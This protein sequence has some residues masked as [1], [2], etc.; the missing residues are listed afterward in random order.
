MGETMSPAEKCI[1]RPPGP[2]IT[3]VEDPIEARAFAVL[4]DVREALIALTAF[5]RR[6][7]QV[8]QLRGFHVLGAT[9]NFSGKDY[10]ELFA[11]GQGPGGEHSYVCTPIVQASIWLRRR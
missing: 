2:V 10:V 9:S 8:L 6:L 4:N 7:E 1:G 3:R 11:L 5:T